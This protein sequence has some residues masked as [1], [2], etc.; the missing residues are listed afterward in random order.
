MQGAHCG[1][2]RNALALGAPRIE[3]GAK[4]LDGA[5]D[6]RVGQICLR[7]EFKK[8]GRNITGAMRPALAKEKIRRSQFVIALLQVRLDRRAGCSSQSILGERPFSGFGVDA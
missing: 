3:S 6:S 8:I 2:K 5:D 7:D 4:R 1:D